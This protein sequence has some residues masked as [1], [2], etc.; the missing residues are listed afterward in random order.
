MA[1]H[2][3]LRVNALHALQRNCRLSFQSVVT[4][5]DLRA[6]IILAVGDLLSFKD[7]NLFF[8]FLSKNNSNPSF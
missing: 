2:L 6:G 4:V 8:V 5:V 3:G 1:L 7:L